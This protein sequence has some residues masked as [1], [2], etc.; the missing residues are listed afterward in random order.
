MIEQRGR[1]LLVF[2]VFCISSDI[3]IA[4]ERRAL[5]TGAEA[6]SFHVKRPDPHLEL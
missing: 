5:G 2:S 4:P 6:G 3:A 1:A